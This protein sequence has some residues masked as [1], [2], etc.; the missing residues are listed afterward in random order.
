MLTILLV[1]LFLY[2]WWRL[3]S[4]EVSNIPGPLCIPFLGCPLWLTSKRGFLDWLTHPS[5]IKN[6]ISFIQIGPTVKYYIIND[7]RI[8]KELFSKEEFSRR[9]AADFQLKHRFVTVN[10]PDGIMLTNGDQWSHQRRFAL[11]TL[12]DFGFGKQ[13][14][15]STINTEI[16]EMITK[17]SLHQGDI[18]IGSDFNIPVISILWKIVSGSRITM[19]STESVR[20]VE[21]VNEIFA[22]GNQVEFSIIR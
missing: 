19:D 16:D 8:L 9:S 2:A 11:K 10:K 4:K 17:Y 20:M 13:S 5:V 1:F 18:K 3:F 15:E 21:L 6:P 22:K 14:L 7:F 12:K